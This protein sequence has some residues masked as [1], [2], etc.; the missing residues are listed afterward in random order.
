MAFAESVA[1]AQEF[2]RSRRIPAWLLY[3][4]RGSNPVF[5][6]L[7]GRVGHV[8]RPAWCLVPRDGEPQFFA[9]HVDAAK[10]LALSAPVQVFASRREMAGELRRALQGTHA[11]AMEYMP[12]GALP[13]AS[14]VDAGTVELVRSLGPRVLSSADLFQYA[15]Q[16]WTL[17]QLASH[18]D[19]AR[20]LTD[21]VHR[22]FA[23]I[24]DASPRP[25]EW[26]AAEFI[27]AEFAHERLVTTEGPTVA[28]NEHASDPHY[29]PS[30]AITRRI[31]PGDWVLIDLWARGPG[32]D[33]I[34]ADIT[35]VGYAGKNIPAEHRRVFD[36]VIGG[37]EAALEY[38]TVGF[39]K[40]RRVQGWQVDQIARRYIAKAGFG[41]F[42]TH[43]LGHS[44]GRTVHGDAVNLDSWETRDTRQLIPGLG[45][46]IEPGI[47][48]PRFGVRS[49]MDV[50]LGERGPEV[51]TPQQR[52]VVL[53][54]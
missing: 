30:P 26:E 53:L 2:M 16:R 42:F 11:V 15:T 36:A 12:I 4:Y 14:R 18:R 19:A 35:W 8:T 44:L 54:A 32:P 46:T 38:I 40:G 1:Q 7:V 41:K 45:V 5:E 21:I 29:D 51:T 27:R 22:T 31:Q 20:K 33:D 10:F 9:H 52:K 23:Y 50:W 6:A 34:Y 43:R 25:T 48:L 24:R 37:R 49:E 13:R 28:V 47:Y 39:A 3:D 17:E